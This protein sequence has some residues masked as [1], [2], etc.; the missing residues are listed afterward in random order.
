MN[1]EIKISLSVDRPLKVLYSEETHD[2][3]QNDMCQHAMCSASSANK[4]A[5]KGRKRL[6]LGGL[7]MAGWTCT[8]AG[9][10][11]APTVPGK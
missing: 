3:P 6:I 5:W 4:S 9:I 2:P 1:F 11:R 10:L 7:G 8:P